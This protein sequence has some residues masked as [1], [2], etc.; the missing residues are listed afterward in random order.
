MLTEVVEGA[1][2]AFGAVIGALGALWL[3]IL[4]D[5]CVGSFRSALDKLRRK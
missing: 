1:L 5:R 3:M 2:W 4:C